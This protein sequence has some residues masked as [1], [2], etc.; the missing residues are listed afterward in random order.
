MKNNKI[1][2]FVRESLV[3]GLFLVVV[4]TRIFS[5]HYFLFMKNLLNKINKKTK[6]DDDFPMGSYEV[7]NLDGLK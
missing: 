5:R 7:I 1:E 2:P 4:T 3:F 6:M